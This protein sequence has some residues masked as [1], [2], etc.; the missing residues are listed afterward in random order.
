MLSLKRGAMKKKLMILFLAILVGAILS[1]P[2][3]SLKK[4]TTI[5]KTTMYVLQLGVYKNYDNALEKKGELEG[6]VIYKNDDNYYVLAGISKE[7]ENLSFMEEC[8]KTKGIPYYKKQMKILYDEDTYDK[9][10]LLLEKIKDE[11][12]LK[13]VNE[14]LLKVVMKDES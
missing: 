5:T 10:V 3:L 2:A 12:S 11:D 13:K 1:I 7:V 4:E 8:L 14:K 6:S 9:Y